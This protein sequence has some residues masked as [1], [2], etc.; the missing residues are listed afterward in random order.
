MKKSWISWLRV[1]V[2]FALAGL[3]IGGCYW[4]RGSKGGGIPR[5]PSAFDVS[6]LN[7]SKARG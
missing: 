5:L 4:M 2:A 7:E 6:R 3:V 1:L